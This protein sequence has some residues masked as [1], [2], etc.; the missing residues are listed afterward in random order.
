M[1]L[2]RFIVREDVTWK[3]VATIQAEKFT[4]VPSADGGV[5]ACKFFIGEI[6]VADVNMIG[7]ACAA[8]EIVEVEQSKLLP[9]GDQQS[10]LEL[11]ALYN[12]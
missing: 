11:R 6:L 5:A 1:K 8:M 3:E 12:K 2:S 10:I 9:D 4:T 7:N